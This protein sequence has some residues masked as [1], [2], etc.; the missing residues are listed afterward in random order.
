M[1]ENREKSR[2][3]LPSQQGIILSKKEKVNSKNLFS[4][5]QIEN[6]SFNELSEELKMIITF[7]FS[8]VM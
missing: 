7:I 1:E 5:S 3:S 2:K 6:Y 4:L 8:L